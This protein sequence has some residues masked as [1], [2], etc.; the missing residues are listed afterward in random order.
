MRGRVS[1]LSAALLKVLQRYSSQG[2]MLAEIQSLH[3]RYSY[4]KTVL[5]EKA[6]PHS[7][8]DTAVPLLQDSLFINPSKTYIH[9]NETFYYF[10][11]IIR[12]N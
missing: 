4:R 7:I 1:E 5:H 3:S 11:A 2:E 6:R 8:H 9:I 10:E 12:I